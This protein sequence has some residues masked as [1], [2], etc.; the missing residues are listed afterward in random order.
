MNSEKVCSKW[1]TCEL[2]INFIYDNF[3]PESGMANLECKYKNVLTKFQNSDCIPDGEDGATA[4]DNMTY[5]QL[6]EQYNQLLEKQKTCEDT[7]E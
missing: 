5:G 4:N 3:L 6:M 7:C 1:S 2:F